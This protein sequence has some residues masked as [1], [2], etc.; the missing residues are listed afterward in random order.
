MLQAKNQQMEQLLSDVA[1]DL[2]TPISLIGMYSS[3]I[4]DGLDDGTFLETIIQQ[5]SRM[6]QMTERLL[7]LSGIERKE[8]PLTTIR[9]DLLLFE[10]IAEQKLFLSKRGLSPVSY[11]HLENMTAQ[12]TRPKIISIVF[13]YRRR[14]GTASSACL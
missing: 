13:R 6:S 4:R 8:Y 3:G 11:T 2:K 12:I 9:L 5:N 10:C 1:H 7:N 14:N